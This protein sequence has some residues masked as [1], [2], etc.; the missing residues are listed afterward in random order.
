MMSAIVDAGSGSGDDSAFFA[1]FACRRA[2]K[3]SVAW[4]SAAEGVAVCTPVG[5]MVGGGVRAGEGW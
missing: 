5:S 1:A 3:A 2:R 4:V